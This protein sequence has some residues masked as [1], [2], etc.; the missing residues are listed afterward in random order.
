LLRLWNTFKEKYKSLLKAIASCEFDQSLLSPISF[1]HCFRILRLKK[2]KVDFLVARFYG[3]FLIMS[4]PT[5]AI[6]MIIAITAAA[7]PIVRPDIVARP[8]IGVAVG[9]GVAG[10]ALA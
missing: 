1:R 5:M 4:K 10:V 2:G 6:A 8:D 7:I 9:A 3:F